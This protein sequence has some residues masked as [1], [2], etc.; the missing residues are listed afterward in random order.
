MKSVII[1]GAS[2]GIGC[3]L[4]SIL[5]DRDIRVYNLSRTKCGYE[6][7]INF[8]VDVTD[9]TRLRQIIDDIIACE[10]NIDAGIYCAGYSIAVPIELADTDKC[11]YLFDVNYFGAVEFAQALIPTMR[12]AG[13]GRIVF[14]GSM[15]GQLPI[16]F[17]SF[18]SSSKAALGMLAHGL[19]QELAPYNIHCSCVMPGGTITPFTAKREKVDCKLTSYNHRYSN[20]LAALGVTEAK[21][22]D[23]MTVAATIDKLLHRNHPPLFVPVGFKN[24]ITASTAKILPDQWVGRIMSEK[25]GI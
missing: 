10:T 6:G 20:A 4:A 14:V 22:M 17:G 19:R 18:Y 1:V 15:A 11:R 5:V 25:F 2:S 3:A 23:A 21:G 8:E 7:I 9:T 16:P 24:R 13:A 12:G